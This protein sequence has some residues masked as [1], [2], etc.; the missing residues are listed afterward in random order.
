MFPNADMDFEGEKA[1][2]CCKMNACIFL[3][4]SCLCVDIMSLGLNM[5]EPTEQGDDRKQ[6]CKHFKDKR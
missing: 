4:K 3:K 2:A 6:K 1:T 5:V